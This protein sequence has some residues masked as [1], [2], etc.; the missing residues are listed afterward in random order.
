MRTIQIGLNRMLTSNGLLNWFN[1]SQNF[2]TPFNGQALSLFL[3]M[4]DTFAQLTTRNP[5]P[6]VALAVIGAIER[7]NRLK[8]S[9]SATHANW[10]ISQE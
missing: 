5:V 10:V 2:L 9:F 3:V 7:T 1:H 6:A 4:N 8:L